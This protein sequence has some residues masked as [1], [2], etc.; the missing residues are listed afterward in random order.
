VTP[1]TR[2]YLAKL[3]DHERAEARR[4]YEALRSEML[5]I[6]R[7]IHDGEK[8]LKSRFEL[9]PLTRQLVV[10]TNAAEAAR[11]RLRRAEAVLGQLR[12]DDSP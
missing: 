6:E 10:T 12:K 5:M 8:A 1:D 7:S 4:R 9:L 3:V 11:Q 2:E